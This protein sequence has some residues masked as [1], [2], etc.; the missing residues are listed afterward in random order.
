MPPTPQPTVIP[1]HATLSGDV[2]TPGDALIA[3]RIAGELRVAG[4]L[5]LAVTGRVD[6]AISA[7]HAS[8]HGRA[9]AGV[10]VRG[11]TELFPGATVAGVLATA[12]LA[13][14]DG[15]R[16]EGRLELGPPAS[17]STAERSPAPAAAAQP[18]PRADANAAAP[19]TPAPAS[20]PSLPFTEVP[21]VA[22]AGLRLRAPAG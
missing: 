1:A 6:G 8:L 20:A 19:C 13:A 21:G 15:A 12:E 4:R 10:T 16:F 7:A 3:G 9:G 18:R 2:H 22:Q 11:Q 17:E 5:T 14:R